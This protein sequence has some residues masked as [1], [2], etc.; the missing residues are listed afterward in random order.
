MTTL[1]CS[2]RK[3]TTFICKREEIVSE[4]DRNDKRVKGFLQ[5]KGYTSWNRRYVILDGQ[6]LHYYRR[7]EEKE[8]K[9]TILLPSAQLVYEQSG[10]DLEFH[11]ETSGRIHHFRCI[12]TEEKNKWMSA[13]Q[14]SV[15]MEYGTIGSNN[16]MIEGYLK[17]YG[18]RYWNTRWC[19]FQG[20]NLLYYASQDSKEPKASIHLPTARLHQ[21]QSQ[22]EAD[23]EFQLE[24]IDRSHFFQTRNKAHK[25]Q[26]MSAIRAVGL[27]KSGTKV[28]IIKGINKGNTGIIQS[29]ANI[30]D[31]NGNYGVDIN[32]DEG[33]VVGFWVAPHD[34]RAMK[35]NN[36][37]IIVVNDT[38]GAT[39]ETTEGSTTSDPVSVQKETE[40]VAEPS[41]TAKTGDTKPPKKI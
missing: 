30:I 6:Y 24:T 31:P 34:L 7:K 10:N 32:K 26:W 36:G 3:I 5:K 8:P 2:F 39:T 19:K 15:E 18:T 25:D 35:D 29:G 16:Q 41:T 1:H 14:T 13:L 37:N 12:N 40:I 9:G 28:E 17:K 11:V 21:E 4:A 27:Y 33:Q 22:S 20:E 23:L 38:S